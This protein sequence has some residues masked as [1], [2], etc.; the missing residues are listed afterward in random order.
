MICTLRIHL[1]LE[2]PKIAAQQPANPPATPSTAPPKPNQ[3]AASP[4]P[5][6]PITVATVTQSPA[7]HLQP[8]SAETISQGV[9][10]GAEIDNLRE[11]LQESRENEAKAI[12]TATLRQSEFAMYESELQRFQS[13]AA[14]ASKQVSSLQAENEGLRA[15][16]SR[17]ET[18]AQ[19]ASPRPGGNKGGNSH[20]SGSPSGSALQQQLQHQY[21]NLKSEIQALKAEITTLRSKSDAQRLK[22]I[23]ADTRARESEQRANALEADLLYCRNQLAT[24]RSSSA[25]S[26]ASAS[27]ASAAPASSPTSAAAAAE[28]ATLRT[29]VME[30]NALISRLQQSMRDAQ[31]T[32]NANEQRHQQEV[33]F[34]STEFSQLRQQLQAQLTA[35]TRGDSADGSEATQAQR[36]AASGGSSSDVAGAAPSTALTRF[37]SSSS[38]LSP[39]ATSK[40]VLAD[41]DEVTDND[42]S[43]DGDE[44][45]SSGA[46]NSTVA[47]NAALAASSSPRALSH[48]R[49][50]STPIRSSGLATPVHQA[51]ASSAGAGVENLLSPSSDTVYSPAVTVRS[52]SVMPH[53]QPQG[54]SQ[55]R[56]GASEGRVTLA[57]SAAQRAT[58]SASTLRI[59]SADR[60]FNRLS[61]VASFGNLTSGFQGAMNSPAASLASIDND[62]VGWNGQWKTPAASPNVPAL[63]SAASQRFVSQASAVASQAQDSSQPSLS[64]SAQ[65]VASQLLPSNSRRI[66]PRSTQAGAGNLSPGGG[67]SSGSADGNEHGNVNEDLSLIRLLKSQI[68]S[69]QTE[70]SRFAPAPQ[71]ADEHDGSRS[72]A[73]AGS[74][75][76]VDGGAGAEQTDDA[77]HD[78]HGDGERPA[79]EQCERL[80]GRIEAQ[81]GLILQLRADIA[82][83]CEGAL[84]SAGTGAASA[85]A[86][87]SDG[88]TEDGDGRA[89]DSEHHN[90]GAAAAAAAAAGVGLAHRL[91]CAALASRVLE[92]VDDAFERLQAAAS[93]AEASTQADADA[94]LQPPV[95][96]ALVDNQAVEAADAAELPAIEDG[97]A[98][99]RAVDQ[100]SATVLADHAPPTDVPVPNDES[101]AAIDVD[102]PLEARQLLES[103]AAA[104]DD[105]KGVHAENGDDVA[106]VGAAAPNAQSTAP[107]ERSDDS[108]QQSGAPVLRMQHPPEVG[109]ISQ[110]DAEKKWASII[111]PAMR[112]S[113]T[114]AA[115][116]GPSSSRLGSAS[117]AYAASS[118]SSSALKQRNA[119]NLSISVLDVSASGSSASGIGRP[120]Y[121]LMQPPP[122]HMQPQSSYTPSSSRAALLA[123]AS[124]S[125]RAVYDFNQQN[126][127][128]I[129]QPLPSARGVSTSS[130]IIGTLDLD[131]SISS[132]IVY[133]GTSAA[134]AY[135]GPSS[136]AAVGPAGISYSPS[137][138]R[139][140][141]RYGAVSVSLMSPPPTA[142]RGTGTIHVSGG[143]GHGG[144]TPSA[145]RST[146]ILPFSVRAAQA[147]VTT[148]SFGH[149]HHAAS[150]Y[151]S[152]SAAPSAF[153]AAGLRSPP[154]SAVSGALQL[155]LLRR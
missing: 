34:L 90:A 54:H 94:G 153:G 105:K 104:M 145:G 39:M 18:S 87:A 129:S 96:H 31:N 20:A 79:C 42:E 45:G 33:Q 67:S 123:A 102:G 121:S 16:I 73:L 122:P 7:L 106:E 50:N 108:A 29:S 77:H 61:S 6:P 125:A 2:P 114:S 142:T 143:Q 15:Q 134:A 70:I 30:K 9:E 59:R 62:P 144:N 36:L 154:A 81:V 107:P 98:S 14:T 83:V 101:A 120:A 139:G 51:A 80:Q 85:A 1:Q 64:S 38:P 111:A 124:A 82:T 149:F 118:S 103:E 148:Q 27:A 46:D 52:P 132:G 109:W 55:Q 76:D 12:N 53:S 48:L 119:H 35:A 11:L 56:T 116:S 117:S 135:A 63:A 71:S 43:A 37:P 13:E 93:A 19:V 26:A 72:A 126:A 97:A 23:A 49:S 150:A 89:D 57:S 151:P 28:L 100:G 127:G 140:T 146:S 69:L 141:S 78:A 40:P 137:V 58:P 8:V 65:V 136:R 41:I 147:G 3:L 92:V 17:L 66:S 152:S 86:I 4:R 10:V 130:N 21:Q 84:S 128:A 115:A 112:H 22:T 24:A 99:E 74:R 68:S 110:A 25:L 95:A 91:T 133:H 88:K 5:G 155:H 131:Q 47:S 44:A 32:L 138:T 75:I 113:Q 60:P